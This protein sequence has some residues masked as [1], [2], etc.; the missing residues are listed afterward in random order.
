MDVAV[1]LSISSHL[2]RPALGRA[3]PSSRGWQGGT[4]LAS[5][6]STYSRNRQARNTSHAAPF[7]RHPPSAIRLRYS[8]RAGV[9]RT[10]GRHYDDDLHARSESR[11]R[12]VVSP[13]DR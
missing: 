9:A 11:G 2:D 10:Q 8:H 1:Y 6:S 13:L 12:G 5:S 7:L 3:T 4:T